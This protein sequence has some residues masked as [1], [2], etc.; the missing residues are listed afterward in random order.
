M[1]VPGYVSLIIAA[2]FA[3]PFPS[4]VSPRPCQKTMGRE[5]GAFGSLKKGFCRDEA[6]IREGRTVRR[7]TVEGKRMVIVV[8]CL[9][10]MYGIVWAAVFWRSL[11][12]YKPRLFLRT[13]SEICDPT[14]RGLQPISEG[15]L[16][17]PSWYPSINFRNLNSQDF[18][19]TQRGWIQ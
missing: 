13:K 4:Y 10:G 19:T 17:H 3:K 5:V 14:N 16:S 11:C 12:K 6:R 18:L 7:R 2:I 9:D 15:L 1:N 8:E